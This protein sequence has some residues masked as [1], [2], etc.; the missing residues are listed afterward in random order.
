[1]ARACIGTSASTSTSH[2]AQRVVR[3]SYVRV[4]RYVFIVDAPIQDDA[5]ADGGEDEPGNARPENSGYDAD[6][7]GGDR[8]ADPKEQFF[9]AVSP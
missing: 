8:E 1:M 7:Y 5:A 3:R 4:T 6:Q 2:V 9:P